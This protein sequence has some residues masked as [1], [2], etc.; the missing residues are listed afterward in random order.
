[1]F[2]KPSPTHKVIE[3]RMVMEGECYNCL[4]KD[5]VKDY[6]QKNPGANIVRPGGNVA[7]K[8]KDGLLAGLE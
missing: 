1:M 5:P 4:A 2:G 6:N 8:K 7:E 3:D